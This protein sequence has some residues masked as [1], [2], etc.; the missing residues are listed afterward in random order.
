MQSVQNLTEL[1]RLSATLQQK[2]RLIPRLLAQYD[3]YLLFHPC[4]RQRFV[5]I[6][7]KE[8]IKA[9]LKLKFADDF[10]VATQLQGTKSTAPSP[11]QM[12]G[13]CFF[14]LHRIPGLIPPFYFSEKITS[15]MKYCVVADE[16]LC[17]V[18]SRTNF[19]SG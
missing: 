13:S 14:R 16:C 8:K 5:A 17:F 19:G 2:Q 11:I 4:A 7:A 10:Y 12:L 3:F 6:R 18:G 15:N 9:R 1:F